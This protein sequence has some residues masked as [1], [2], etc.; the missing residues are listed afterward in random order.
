MRRGPEKDK[1]ERYIYTVTLGYD[2]RD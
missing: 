1:T 2:E